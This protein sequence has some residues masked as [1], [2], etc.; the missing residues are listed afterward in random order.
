[1]KKIFSLSLLLLCISSTSLL[2]AAK[3]QESPN[4]LRLEEMVTRLCDDGKEADLPRT[5]RTSPVEFSGWEQASY[6]DGTA[7]QPPTPHGQMP[8]VDIQRMASIPA[9]MFI[10]QK[11]H[12]ANISPLDPLDRSFPRFVIQLTKMFPLDTWT[13]IWHVASNDL[14]C[15]RRSFMIP[16]F[17]GYHWW[18]N[19]TLQYFYYNIVA[20]GPN[21][22]EQIVAL[23]TRLNTAVRHP[24]VI[25]NP[26]LRCLYLY[27]LAFVVTTEKQL[28][29]SGQR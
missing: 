18:I 5:R 22:S 12:E 2:G 10:A 24:S 21:R 25:A 13:P 16:H 4:K 20:V 28:M 6:E 3:T 29:L 7:T 23:T 9:R 26:D 19:E 17:G 11:F 8:S 15:N 14:L 27:F 1:M